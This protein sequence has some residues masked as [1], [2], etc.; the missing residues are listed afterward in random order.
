MLKRLPEN[1]FPLRCGRACP[2]KTVGCV[3]LGRWKGRLNGTMEVGG[4]PLGLLLLANWFG[5]QRT[6]DRSGE[7]LARRRNLDRFPAKLIGFMPKVR[8]ALEIHA[9]A[10]RDRLGAWSKSFPVSSQVGSHHDNAYPVVRNV[11][12][13]QRGDPVVCHCQAERAGTGSG[14]AD[15]GRCAKRCAK[16]FYGRD[17]PGGGRFLSLLCPAILGSAHSLGR[18][19]SGRCR[20]PPIPAQPPGF[21]QHCTA[22]AA[23]VGEPFNQ[24]ARTVS[25]VISF[26]GTRSDVG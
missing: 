8:L 5:M 1:F 19:G 7:L 25:C 26:G 10:N 9:A 13:A 4:K 16:P 14:I 3:R 21:H 15:V 18:R 6:P 2:G 24:Q 17:N 23:P 12:V 20:R 22:T 11:V